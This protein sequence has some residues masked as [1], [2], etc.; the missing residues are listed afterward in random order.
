MYTES[1]ATGPSSA[2]NPRVEAQSEDHGI[3]PFLGPVLDYTP[4]KTITIE[5]R[6]SL[7]ED[8]YLAD[9]AFVHAPGLKPLA[10]CLPVLPLTMSLEAMA[11]VAACLVPGCGLLGFEEIKAARWIELTDT[12]VLALQITA[13]VD[14]H[15]AGRGT[16]FLRVAIQIEGQ[17]QPAVSGAVLFGCR[18]VAELCP[19]FNE[20]S[21][22]HRHPLSAEQIYSERHMFHGPC[23]QGLAGEIIIGDQGIAG[24]F[25]VRSPE[26]LF[27]S[28]RYPQ[29]LADPALLDAVGQLIGIFA[30]ELGR[31]AFPIGL[32][33]LEIY[34]PTPPPGT[35]VPAR[36]EIT[37]S[38]G[39]VLY[40]NV[41]IENG[42]G[43]VWMRIADWGSWKFRWEQRVADFRR[44][45]DKYL[46]AKPAP[47]SDD[48]HPGAVILQL[49][50]GDLGNFDLGMLARYFLSMEE[51]PIFQN[52]A[53][54]PERQRQWLLGRVAAKD[55]V[56]LWV[57]GQGRLNMLHPAAITLSNDVKGRPF[58]KALPGCAKAPQVSIAHCEDRA[59]ATAH[60]G[61][62]G[63]DIERISARD[64]SFI[65]AFTTPHERALIESFPET[66][67]HR[68]ITR[69]WCAKEAA[70]KLLGTGV[71]GA[72]QQFET[73]R[74]S[75]G[76]HIEVMHKPSAR[77]IIVRT[78]E[79]SGFIMA[80]ATTPAAELADNANRVCG[81]V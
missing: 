25:V 72:A 10:A 14:R 17:A 24:E 60:Y 27:R 79:E 77:P 31:T 41:E 74:A 64:A 44:L 11:E 61:E 59:I 15:D 26:A 13:H 36:V 50:A 52:H 69:I 39:M 63:V 51:M 47:F 40:A 37:R 22:A 78:A 48:P 81:R 19:T 7:D 35:R 67:R 2:I 54:V 56:R 3:L 42:A 65:D 38:E 71:D 66:E 1:S 34:S 43:A 4:G 49:T 8:L 32:K 57:A 75:A 45:P 6:L 29:L 53:R 46:V 21:A 73:L 18:Y 20:L 70:G 58:V 80:C 62:V 30:A 28:T 9:H 16:T 33:K 23:F 5:R 76:S 55:A 12:E 68:L